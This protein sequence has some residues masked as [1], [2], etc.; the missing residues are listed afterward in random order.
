MH[1]LEKVIYKCDRLGLLQTFM[2]YSFPASKNSVS[3]KE[4]S[5]NVQCD[6][7][8]ERSSFHCLRCLIRCLMYSIFRN[9]NGRNKCIVFSAT[10]TGYNSRWDAINVGG[11]LPGAWSPCVFEQKHSDAP[12]YFLLHFLYILPSNFLKRCLTFYNKFK[13]VKNK[14]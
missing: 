2:F 11:C 5:Q 10:P 14:K 3:N 12:N 7:G 6:T 1:L 8:K 4:K 9:A 13:T